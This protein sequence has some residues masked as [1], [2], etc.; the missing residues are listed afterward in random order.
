MKGKNCAKGDI[1]VRMIGAVVVVLAMVKW[2]VG[3]VEVEIVVVAAAVVVAV[4]VTLFVIVL[5]SAVI[6]LL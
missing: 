1:L 2:V 5:A 4:V 6:A 3:I